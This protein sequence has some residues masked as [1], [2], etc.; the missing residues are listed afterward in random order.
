[1]TLAPGAANLELASALVDQFA[2]S[3]LRNAVICPG[4]RSTPLAVALASH[5]DLRNWV[6][7]DERAAAYFALG[8]ARQ[9]AAPVAVLSTSGTAAANFLPAVVEARLSRI[10][11]LVL[12]ADRPPELRDWGAAQTIDQIQLFGSHVKWFVDMPVPVADDALVR[13]AQ[14]TAARAVQAT[15]SDPAGP[16]HL[17]LPF[18]EPLLPAD[19]RQSLRSRAISEH[20][21]QID[22]FAQGDPS[23]LV[24]AAA[25][26]DELAS[27]IAREA[28]GI[29]VCGPGDAPGLA[30]AAVTLS[31]ASGYPILADPLSGVRFGPHDH[32]GV[33]DAYDPFL[34][35]QETTEAMQ[36]QLVIRVGAVPTSKPLQQF[37]QARPDRVQVVIDAGTPRDPSHLATSY[38]TA[39]A[40]T[41][42]ANLAD[43]VANFGG[44]ANREWLDAWKAADH[45]T[46]AAIASAM[47]REEEPS[48]GRAVAEVAALLPEGATIVV[49]NSMPIRDVDAFVRGDRRRLRIVS[50]RGANGIDGV[51][52]TALGAAAV[53]DGPLVLIVGDLSFFHDLNGLFAAA[54]F[55]LD[56]TVVVLNNDGG[57][58]FSFLPQAE[59]LDAETFEALFGTPTG[60]DVGT[61]AR[62]FGASHARPGDWDAFRREICRAMR[63]HGV[64]IIELVTDRNRNVAQHRS[65]WAAVAEALRRDSPIGA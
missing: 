9:H 26:L 12:T 33:I 49:G 17:N 8:M 34:R 55:R 51:V 14:A 62:L 58:I 65:V 23:R 24:S 21:R 10:P 30:A 11:L 52:S 38:I 45:L 7:I 16:V 61:A 27:Q 48:E 18:R 20:A 4:S 2:A 37:L 40:A 54:K 43:K 28:R 36:P 47:A 32:A 5:P 22:L 53:A 29:I 1:V 25:A 39:D 50:N 59:Q 60:L 64:S 31:E 57:G 42:L 56:A 13:H 44:S 46:G 15:R 41:T 63:G 19:L 3:G 6:L 35:D